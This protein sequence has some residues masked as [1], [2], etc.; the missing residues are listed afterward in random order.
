FAVRFSS[1]EYFSLIVLGLVAASSVGSS[2]MMK[3]LAMVV[4]GIMLGVVGTDLYSGPQRFTFGSFDLMGGLS[5]VA[6]SMGVFGISEIIFSVQDDD[7]RVRI[8]G[9]SVRMRDMLPK[10]SEWSSLGMP[11]LRGTTIGSLLGALPGTGPAIAAYMAYSIENRVSRNKANFGKGA[12][13]GIT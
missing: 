10:K 8:T 4:I 6:L 1:V 9:N 2:S 12:P 5:L 3:G 11:V 13:E 7:K